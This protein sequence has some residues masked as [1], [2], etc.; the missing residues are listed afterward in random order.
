MKSKFRPGD[1]VRIIKNTHDY[2]SD[3]AI[4]EY[5]YSEKYGGTSKFE[6]YS[7]FFERTGSRSWVYG[8]EMELIESAQHNL[9]EKWKNDLENREKI[10][11]NLDWIFSQGNSFMKNP[12]GHAA[13]A[14]F[15]SAGF[16]SLW[17]NHGEAFVYLQNARA[18][19]SHAEPFIINK[20]KEGW[21]EYA[22][23]LKV[24]RGE[25]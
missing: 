22:K 5:S 11:S 16:G 21:L 19:L 17:G 12:S 25:S 10:E 2:S 20:D 13:Q 6:D 3:M 15:T 7:L 9:L 8:S 23:S 4:V 14:L 18:I 1:L 24:K